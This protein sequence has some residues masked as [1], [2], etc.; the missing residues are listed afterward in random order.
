MR[1]G[2]HCHAALGNALY[3]SRLRSSPHLIHHDDL[4]RSPMLSWVQTH[5]QLKTLPLIVQ[6]DEETCRDPVSKH[7]HHLKCEDIVRLATAMRQIRL[8]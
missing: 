3:G 4:Q 1:G 6:G 2:Y 8:Q 5:P 7:K